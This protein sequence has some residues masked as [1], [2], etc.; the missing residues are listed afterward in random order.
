MKIEYFSKASDFLVKTAVLL[1][2]DEARYGLILRIAK[3]LVENPHAY[4]GADPWFCI[5]NDNGKI[6]A[7]A[8]RTPPHNVLL[9]H[10][11]GNPASEAV[12]QAD[13][14]SKRSETIPGTVGDIIIAE[15]FAEHWCQIHGIKITGKMVQ[16][17]YR[18]ER[19]NDVAFTAGKLRLAT[20]DDSRI[21][22]EWAHMFHAEADPNT[23]E[24]NCIPRIEKRDIFLWEDGIPV[25]MV[26]KASPTQK[27]IR[28][29]LVYTP[30]EL[31]NKGYATSCV[32][33]LCK[34]LLDSGYQFCMLYADLANP[35]SNSI[36]QKIGFKTVCDS[37]EY[38]FSAPA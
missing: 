14:I 6:L 11:S 13:S 26:A 16:R 33:A 9:A 29:N 30:R 28:I 3:K 38:S 8:M 2:K 27:G 24:D 32:A 23:P 34:E 15:P 36:Y 1:E 35:T 17:I 4:S 31:R 22:T 7:A 21:I 18:L 25:S 37:V 10:F 5:V 19:I 12:A 20:M